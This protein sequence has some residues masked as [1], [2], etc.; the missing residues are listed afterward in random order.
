M[1][2]TMN[3][4]RIEGATQKGVGAVKEGLGKAL[5]NNKLR[6][7]GMAD[8]VTGSAKETVGKVKDAAAKHAR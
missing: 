8:K 5:G 6:A 2:M 3:K 7:E 1:E 4:D